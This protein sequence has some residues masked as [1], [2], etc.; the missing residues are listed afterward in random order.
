MIKHRLSAMLI[1]AVDVGPMT[2]PN[3]ELI[4]SL[5]PDLILTSKVRH[6]KI[7]SKLDAIARTVMA[8]TTG[9]PWKANLA[10]Y[11]RALGKESEAETAVAQYEARAAKL[12]E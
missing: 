11:A 10:L 12:G 6:E 9:F 5:K 7:Y 1:A 2:E 3:L 8:E 4:A